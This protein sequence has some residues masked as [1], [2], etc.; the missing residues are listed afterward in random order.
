MAASVKITAFRDSAPCSLVEVDRRCGGAIIRAMM[1][2]L[3]IA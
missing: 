1:E 2:S 3:R